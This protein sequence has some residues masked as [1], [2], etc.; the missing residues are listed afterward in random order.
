MYHPKMQYTYAGVDSHKDSHTVVFLNC[1][2]EKLGEITFSSKPNAFQSF[3]KKSE[4]YRLENTTF[5]F[6]FEDTAKY[7]RS[8]VKFLL[9]KKQL[10]KHTN[11]VLV[12]SERTSQNLLNK[13]DS[14]DAECCAR[15]L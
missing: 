9:Q 1:F 7:G 8:L 14:V 12:A 5:A 11:S 4:K 10:V 6:G 3:L 2:Y 13:T 15:V